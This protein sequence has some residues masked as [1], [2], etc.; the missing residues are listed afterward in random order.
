MAYLLLQLVWVDI[1]SA[2]SWPRSVTPSPPRAGG[3]DYQ[4]GFC[5]RKCLTRDIIEAGD[6]RCGDRRERSYLTRFQYE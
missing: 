5:A 1:V 3:K 4:L 2:T 6:S